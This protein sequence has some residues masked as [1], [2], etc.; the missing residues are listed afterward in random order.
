MQWHENNLELL[1]LILKQIF[2]LFIKI[3][4]ETVI[5]E[6]GNSKFLKISVC[7]TFKLNFMEM[8]TGNTT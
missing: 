1:Y 6:K 7:G 3:Q 8:K 4:N 2:K 5:P